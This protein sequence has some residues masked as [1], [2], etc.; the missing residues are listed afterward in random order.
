MPYHCTR[1]YAASHANHSPS[2]IIKWVARAFNQNF[3]SV[4]RTSWTSCLSWIWKQSCYQGL[5]E[6]LGWF[7]VG[8]TLVLCTLAE[9][10]LGAT[11]TYVWVWTWRLEF[12]C[13]I[14]GSCDAQ[15]PMTT[16][17]KSILHYIS[18]LVLIC[19]FIGV[20]STACQVAAYLVLNSDV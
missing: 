9:L 6:D 13:T 2:L 15:E 1:F 10:G 18:D 12:L 11:C 17:R 16:T 19:H 7:R 14:H 4:V 5:R 3:I 20:A 8:W